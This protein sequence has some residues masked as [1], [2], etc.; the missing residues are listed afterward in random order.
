MNTTNEHHQRTYKL[1]PP[2][3]AVAVSYLNTKPLLYGI[4]QTGLDAEMDI[5]LHVPSICAQQLLSG[6]AQIGLVP[7][8]ALPSL[9]NAQII[10]D[11]CIGAEG[12][13]RTVCI[14]SQVPIH[15]IT[16]LHLDFHSRTSVLL[17]QVLLKEY[18]QLRPVIIAADP[19][20]PPIIE[21]TTAAVLIGDKTFGLESQYPYIY[22]LAEIWHQHTNLPFVFAVWV[23]MQPLSAN[24]LTRFN[25][26]LATGISHIPQLCQLIPTPNAAYTLEE[27]YTKYISY[28]YDDAKKTA[29]N[30]FL[31]KIKKLDT[32]R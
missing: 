6:A 29:L 12:A 20:K 9:P 7:V 15:E 23:S 19:S 25:H 24:F 17:A 18:W 31:E 13:V 14:Y 11:Y 26:A 21:G 30:L 4:F 3:Q 2:L 16:H 5:N 32:I 8:G 27:Y 22:D 10:S 28:Y 1:N